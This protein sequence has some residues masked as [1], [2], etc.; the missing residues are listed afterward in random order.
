[1]WESSPTL[2]W[3][4]NAQP[5]SELD[6]QCNAV[7][8]AIAIYYSSSEIFTYNISKIL[9]YIIKVKQNFSKQLLRQKC[10]ILRFVSA[11]THVK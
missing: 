6:N 7:H 9:L 11:T 1:M 3:E 5:L 10:F 2:P 4:S 8:K